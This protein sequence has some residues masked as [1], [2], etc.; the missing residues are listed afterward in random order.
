MP[1]QIPGVGIVAVDEKAADM[2]VFFA[3]H[4]H[5]DQ[6]DRLTFTGR[7]AGITSY[8]N[9]D[10]RSRFFANGFRHGSGGLSTHGGVLLYNGRVNTQHLGFYGVVVA[11][12]AAAKDS[13]GP[14]GLW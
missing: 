13:G 7:G 4:C 9:A 14:G 10:I 8:P 5:K 11:Y 12:N 6:P 3:G 1:D 2:A